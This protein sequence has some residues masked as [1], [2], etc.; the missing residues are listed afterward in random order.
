MPNALVVKVYGE[1][2]GII[3]VFFPVFVID[4]PLIVNVD[5]EGWAEAWATPPR[6]R[7]SWRSFCHIVP[8]LLRPLILI[9]SEM[10]QS[11][12]HALQWFPIPYNIYG[13]GG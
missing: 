11:S 12:E 2:E 13:G 10:D 6:C 8:A 5:D 7:Y 1:G 9:A 3:C 4:R